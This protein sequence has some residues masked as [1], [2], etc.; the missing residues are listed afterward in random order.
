MHAAQHGAARRGSQA[1]VNSGLSWPMVSQALAMGGNSLPSPAAL[2]CDESVWLRVS[3][4]WV[5][6]DMLDISV[7]ALP[8]S[9]KPTYWIQ[10]ITVAMRAKSAGQ[11]RCCQ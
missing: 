8:L 11:A 7:T 6:H 10:G 4:R 9:R 1:R 3:I 5:W 2:P